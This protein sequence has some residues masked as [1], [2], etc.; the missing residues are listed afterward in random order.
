MF[1]GSFADF[2]EACAD[3]NARDHAAIMDAIK[4]RRVSTPAM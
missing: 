3:Q 2:A 1:D 4:W